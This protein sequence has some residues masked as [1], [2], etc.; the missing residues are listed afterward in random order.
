MAKTTISTDELI[1]KILETAD[2]NGVIRNPYSV[3]V[4]GKMLK[5]RL[6]YKAEGTDYIVD[7]IKELKGIDVHIFL[8]GDH[9]SFL[10]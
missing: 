7:R 9:L 6:R 4:Y 2:E 1:L 8:K 10:K 3:P 5:D